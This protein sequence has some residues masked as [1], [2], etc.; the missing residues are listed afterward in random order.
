[1]KLLWSVKHAPKSVEDSKINLGEMKDRLMNMGDGLP[2]HIILSGPI[3]SG[4]LLFAKLWAK[5]KVKDIGDSIRVV[6]AETSLTKEERKSVKIKRSGKLGSFQ[7]GS[8]GLPKFLHARCGDFIKSKPLR[9]PYKILI[10]REFHKIKKQE[11]FRRIMEKDAYSHC[12]MILTTHNPSSI[13][14]PI[15]SRCLSVEVKKMNFTDF[16]DEIKRVGN[17]EGFEVPLILSKMLYSTFNGNIGASVDAIQL[18]YIQNGS[19]T[20]DDVKK[21]LEKFQPPSIIPLIQSAFDRSLGLVKRRLDDMLKFYDPMQLYVEINNEIATQNI[22][23]LGDVLCYLAR[24]EM[25]LIDCNDKRI[26]LI[27]ILMN[28]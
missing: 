3:G 26:Q 15:E 21:V 12:R 2:P 11:S 17:E 23:G 4:K 16:N 6:S 25:K 9:S 24:N 19:V 7:S 10:I 20:K 27:D 14:E 13:L 18:S 1:M 22:E 28:I 5:S 8:F